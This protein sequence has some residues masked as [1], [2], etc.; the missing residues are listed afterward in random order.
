MYVLEQLKEKWLS[1]K[2]Y[3]EQQHLKQVILKAN[4][5]MYY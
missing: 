3:E 4:K 2:K 5:K 1:T